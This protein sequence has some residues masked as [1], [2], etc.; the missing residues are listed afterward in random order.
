[1]GGNDQ[2]RLPIEAQTGDVLLL[3]QGGVLEDPVSAMIRQITGSPYS[4]S[5]VAL[6]DGQYAHAT[7]GPKTDVAVFDEATLAKYL[8]NVERVDL[9]KPV[10]PRPDGGQLLAAVEKLKQADKAHGSADPTGAVFSDGALVGLAVLRILQDLPELTPGRE[11]LKNA[12]FFALND[13]DDRLFCSE[14]VFRALDMAG[15]RPVL[16]PHPVISTEE[17]P[18]DDP[19]PGL[20]GFR[21][22][23]EGWLRRFGFDKDSAM[24]VREVWNAIWAAY[25][26]SQVPQKIIRANF[27]A[28]GDLAQSP[29]FGG[30]PV[31]S[32]TKDSNGWV[33][34]ITA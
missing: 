20:V 7:P 16:G 28:P 11:R 8:Q 1:M 33:A 13:T 34:P 29:S 15:T 9:F 17:F 18:T 6:G 21:E 12:T 2:A 25:E 5:I 3:V 23:V 26:R 31:A 27:V 22:K 24:T 10:G 14:F 32:R 19:H 30:A 4:H